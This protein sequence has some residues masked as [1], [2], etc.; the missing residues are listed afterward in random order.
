MH[1]DAAGEQVLSLRID[2]AIA[3]GSLAALRARVD[4]FGLHLAKLDVRVHARAVHE[5]DE[6]LRRLLTAAGDAQRRHGTFKGPASRPGA[7]SCAACRS[8]ARA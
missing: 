6:P 1:V 5:P 4:L 2:D 7:A 8:A 3:D